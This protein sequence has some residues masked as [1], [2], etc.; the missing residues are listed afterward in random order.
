MTDDGEQSANVNT[1]ILDEVNAAATWFHAKKTAPLWAKELEGDQT[2]ETLEGPAEAKAGDFL[3]RGAAGE[4]WPQSADR[5]AAA[6]NLFGAQLRSLLDQAPR[7]SF[8]PRSAPGVRVARSRRR[9]CRP[10]YTLSALLLL[11]RLRE[12][13]NVARHLDVLR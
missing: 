12:R 11:V 1:V 10:S 9:I 8:L 6:Q 7:H 3:C 5:L 2:I 13:G 4:F